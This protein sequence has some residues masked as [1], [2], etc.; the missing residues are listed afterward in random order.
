[1]RRP[2]TL[3]METR[4][5][6][7]A[8]PGHH[9]DSREIQ[10][11]AQE[12][13]DGRP[14]CPNV[15]PDGP[16]QPNLRLEV[17]PDAN[18][19]VP[20]NLWGCSIKGSSINFEQMISFFSAPCTHFGMSIPLYF[21]SFHSVPLHSMHFL[22]T[23]FHSIPF[24]SIPFHSIPFHSTPLAFHSSACGSIPLHSKRFDSIPLTFNST[25]FRSI[26]KV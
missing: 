11:E 19:S 13:Q 6:Q 12:P 9:N 4:T 24:H 20:E 3:K 2:R 14:G 7:I 1:M 18:V 23:P 22:F 17:L 16:W 26:A 10:D 8:F 25:S 15:C 5:A 21:I